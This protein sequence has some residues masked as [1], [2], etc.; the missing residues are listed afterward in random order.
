[1]GWVEDLAG[2]LVGLDTAPLIY[3]IEEDPTY[4]PLLDPF[5]QALAGGELRV[6]TST[7]TLVEVLTQPLRQG[8]GELARQYRD[9]LL[10]TEGLTV[11]AVSAAIAEEAA[12][13]RAVHELRTP[14]A[15]QLA[16][17]RLAGAYSFVTNDRRLPAVPELT[18][19]V[20][21]DLRQ[22]ERPSDSNT[23]FSHRSG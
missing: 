9:L 19:I 18:T 2:Q 15:I 14:D 21:D 16:S 23:Y 20:L 13:L 4:L 22:S 5:F 11:R 12:R 17:A 6:V 1:V 8:A 3:Y 10:S 7:V